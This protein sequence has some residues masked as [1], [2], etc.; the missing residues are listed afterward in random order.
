MW[1]PGQLVTVKEWWGNEVYR[2][3]YGKKIL[4]ACDK[5]DRHQFCMLLISPCRPWVKKLPWNGYL[6]KLKRSE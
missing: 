2:V 3:H 6:K 4:F 5:C 1:K